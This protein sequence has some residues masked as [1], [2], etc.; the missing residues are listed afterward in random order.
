MKD[1]LCIGVVNFQAAWGNIPENLER[2]RKFCGQAKDLG[3]QMIV[4]PETALTGYSILEQGAMHRAAA[5]EIPGEASREILQM[6]KDMGLYLAVGMP[7]RKAGKI[8]NSVLAVSP[9]GIGAVYQKIHPFGRELLWCAKGQA[10]AI[11]ETPWG[12]VGIGICY[13]T[14]QFPELIR[15]YAARGCRL[16]LNCTAQAG[17]ADTPRAAERFRQYY[18]STIEAAALSNE[19]FLA[20]SNLCGQEKGTHFGGGSLVIGPVPRAAG[21]EE[22]PY[23]KVYAGGLENRQV[24][25]AVAEIDLRLAVRTIYQNNSLAGEPDYRPHLYRSW[26]EEKE[27]KF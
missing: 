3:A 7:E 4:F 12:K 15:Y 9:G 8:Y 10:P 21:W 2:I 13:D 27:E 18:F 17:Q 24:G 23:C 25:I 6:A 5:Q 19:I 26:L 16:Y 11:W 22:D 14:Y 20:S 1:K